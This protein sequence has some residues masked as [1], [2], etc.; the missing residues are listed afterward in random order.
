MSRNNIPLNDR[1]KSKSKI[2]RLICSIAALVI[3]CFCFHQADHVL[4]TGPAERAAAK[5]E[6]AEAKAK[7]EASTPKVTTANIVAV[8]DNLYHTK[9]YESG[10]NDSGEWNYDHVYEHMTSYIQEADLAF[11]DQETVLTPNHDEISS[12]PSFAT[13]QEVGDAVVKAGFDVIET[14]TNHIDDFGLD[15]IKDELNYWETNHPEVTVIGTNATEEERDEIKT[16]TVNDIT[17]ALLDYTYGTNNCLATGEDA[18]IINTFD[19]EQVA[20][21][22]KKAKEI[23]DCVIFVSHWGNEEDPAPSEYEKQWA[24]FLMQ[25]GV[26]VCIGGHPHILQPYGT[27]SDDQG[28]EM[29]IFYSLGNFASTQQDMTGLLGGMA[30]FTLEKTVKNGK[31]SVK[32]IS[33]SV[34]PLVMHYN[35]DQGVYAPYLLKDYTNELAAEHSMH[36]VRTDEFTVETL[37][38]LYDEIMSQ[39]VEPSTGTGL[40]EVHFDGYINMVDPDGNI[41]DDSYQGT[42]QDSNGNSDGEEGTDSSS[43]D[44]SSSDGSDYDDSDYDDSSYDD[45]GYDNSSYDDSS[46]DDSS[47]DDSGYDDSSYDDSGYD[48]SGY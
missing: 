20:T 13:P 17:I 16:V 11:I 12:Y 1:E 23:S 22:I 39:K 18:Y 31:S 5:K 41:V 24:T 34:E 2:S 19:K 15:L 25:Q 40:L 6:A 38:E 10:M 44:E 14:A 26:D 30:Q 3:L 33:K 4:I 21:D 7:E 35:H 27:L 28:N 43:S 32:V 45:S 8:G 37:Y 29:L 48:D 42:S 46:Y 9:L 47:Y 36:E